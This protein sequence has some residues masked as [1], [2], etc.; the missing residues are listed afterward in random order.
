M[1]FFCES[2]VAGGENEAEGESGPVVVPG[3]S[4]ATVISVW[5]QQ[6]ARLFSAGGE[7]EREV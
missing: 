3:S 2:G 6:Q 5:V 1:P 7:D 4:F